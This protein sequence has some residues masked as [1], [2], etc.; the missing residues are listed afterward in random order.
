MTAKNGNSFNASVQINADRRGI[1]FLFL[2]QHKQNQ[3]QDNA[4]NTVSIPG[5]LRG[6]VL[7]EK[8]QETLKDG[9]SIYVEGMINA[10]GLSYNA[11]IK[12]NPE[13]KKLDFFRWNPD[14]KQNVTPDNSGE[15][16]VAVN[17]Q[18]KNN[19]ATKHSTEPLKSD[20]TQPTEMQQQELA[21][22]EEPKKAKGV[23]M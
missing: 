12:V 6:V 5:K 8:Q 14:K 1:E 9:S 22:N 11:Y 20:Q 13:E 19:E 21:K 15:T 4:N 16:Q 3:Q 2:E 18:G 17:S 10:K 23:K 7:S